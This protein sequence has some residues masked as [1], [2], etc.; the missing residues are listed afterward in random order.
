M[1]FVAAVPGQK[2]KQTQIQ[3]V[4]YV[5]LYRGM[6]KVLSYKVFFTHLRDQSQE[7]SSILPPH[8]PAMLTSFH[9]K[10]SLTFPANKFY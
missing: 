2:R 10:Q 4:T 1:L 6:Y 8:C 3:P 9:W 7:K 5:F